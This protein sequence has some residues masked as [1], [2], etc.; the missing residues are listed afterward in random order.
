[1]AVAT[2]RT[3]IANPARRR[4]PRAR[5][6]M[7]AKQIKFFG[8][9]AQRSALKRRKNTGGSFRKTK[10]RLKKRGTFH[11]S[12]YWFRK[13]SASRG[14]TQRFGVS[15]KK[16]RKKKKNAAQNSH[17]KRSNP[18]RRTRRNVGE[19][20]SLV[21]GNPS[22]RKTKGKSMAKARRR[23][24]PSHTRR[25]RRHV[26]HRT[27]HRN[28]TGVSWG[29][30][31]TNALFIVGGAV[32]S[33]LGAQ[34]ILGTNNTGV[35]GYAGNLAVGGVLAWLTASVMKNRPAA[36]A[37][38]AG[39]VVQVVLRAI[40]D[41][42]PFGQYTQQLGMGDYMASN[43]VTP[44]RYTDG[45]NSANVQIPAGWAPQTI[46]QSSGVPAGMASYDGM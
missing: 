30:E 3:S 27:H 40:A 44:Q 23:K 15:L 21:L 45:L 8:T 34:M 6:K 37:V 11:P 33:K 25:T 4:K 39:S 38:F 28:P 12:E 24:N 31:I 29:S 17:R 22:R 10:K 16:P 35:I 5:K 2:R 19:V 26:A 14:S 9:K 32:G 36:K 7:S 13:K 41:Y 42:T 1:M 46:V 18:G 43:W 20:V